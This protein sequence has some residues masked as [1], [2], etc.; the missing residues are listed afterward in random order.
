M[1]IQRLVEPKEPTRAT[2]ELAHDGAKGDTVQRVAPGYRKNPGSRRTVN[3]L[4]DIVFIDVI[5]ILRAVIVEEV[6]ARF[7]L[8]RILLRI[9]LVNPVGKEYKKVREQSGANAA[10]RTITKLVRN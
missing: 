8:L 1:A 9:L 4:S 6:I 2:R 7:L 5:V 3:L 10:K